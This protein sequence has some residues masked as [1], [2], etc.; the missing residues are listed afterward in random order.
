MVHDVFLSYSS[1][2]KQAADAACHSLE[3]N[4]IQ[5]WMAPRNIWAGQGWAA[6]IIRAINDTQIM[7]LIFS[8]NAN[9]SAQIEREVER[10]VNREFQFFRSGWKTSSRATL[11]SISSARI[12]GWMLLRHL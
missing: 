8:S 7:V 12:I 11:L 4:G 3:R 2:D 1:K 10:A 5:V 9:T 6:S